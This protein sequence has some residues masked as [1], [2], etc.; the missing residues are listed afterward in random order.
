MG[1]TQAAEGALKSGWTIAADGRI[2]AG[3]QR[4]RSGIG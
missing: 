1:E 3:S 4:D 2:A